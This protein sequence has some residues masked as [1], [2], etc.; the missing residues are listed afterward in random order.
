MAQGIGGKREELRLL[1]NL[2]KDKAW[3]LLSSIMQEQANSLQDTI[4]FTPLLSLDSSFAQEYNKGKLDG[5]LTWEQTR[6]TAM[7][8]LEQEIS[9]LKEI[10]ENASSSETLDTGD[11][12]STNPAGAP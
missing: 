2:G 7:E 10:E 9:R 6:E 1:E 5:F 12:S 4:L 8:V 3:L 11:K